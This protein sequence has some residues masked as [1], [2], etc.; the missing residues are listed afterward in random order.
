MVLSILYFISVVLEAFLVCKPVQF[1]WDKTIEGGSCKGENIAYLVSGITNLILDV[2]IVTMPMPLLLG[3]H[4][5]MAK[6]LSI[7]AM[8]GLGIV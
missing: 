3:L 5:S 7:A 8:F 2:I 4:M 6:R 1:I